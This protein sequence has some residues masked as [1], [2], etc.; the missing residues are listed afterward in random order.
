VVRSLREAFPF[1]QFVTST[2]D[3]LALRGLRNGEVALLRRNDKGI[4]VADQNLPPIEGLQV[5]QLLTSRVFGLNSTI[6]PETEAL[7]DEL[8]HLLSLAPDAAPD[9][10]R[11]R[12]ISEIRARV[13]D[14]EA[15]GRSEA[16][17]L[18]FQAA[19]QYIRDTAASPEA[20][21]ALREDTLA[22][23]RELAARGAAMQESRNR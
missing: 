21:L 19:E 11:D 2:H 16:E 13:G 17:R 12:R 14:R 22:R 23:L 20:R 18:M 10:L 8:Y 5:D 4:V 7:L 15:L 3:P 9:A 1:V 6:D